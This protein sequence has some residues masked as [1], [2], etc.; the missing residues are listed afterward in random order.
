MKYLAAPGL[1]IPVPASP[2]QFIP[3]AGEGIEVEPL[4][5]YF[6]R[7]IAD[8]DLVPAPVTTSDQEPE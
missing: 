3:D 5:P 4:L 2:G 6:A 8:R 1:R 7:M